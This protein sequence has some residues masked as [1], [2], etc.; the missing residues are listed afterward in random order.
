MKE[1]V[2]KYEYH[3]KYEKESNKKNIMKIDIQ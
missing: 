2:D 1:E 3:E